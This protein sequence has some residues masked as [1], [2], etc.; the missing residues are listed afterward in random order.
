MLGIVWGWV[1]DVT[2]KSKALSAGAIVLGG[3]AVGLAAP[4]GGVETSRAYNF[5]SGYKYAW[6][7]EY[8]NAVYTYQ[9]FDYG[10]W[11]CNQW[12]GVCSV[13]LWNIGQYANVINTSCSFMCW[14]QG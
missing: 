10:D 1:R 8:E 4:L 5:N 6:G 9:T 7:S 11:A 2:W 13:Y 3:V 12:T 14:Y